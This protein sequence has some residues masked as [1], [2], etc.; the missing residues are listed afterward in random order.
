MKG[1]TIDL[2]QVIA[3]A[4][5][6]VI[7]ERDPNSTKDQCFEQCRHALETLSVLLP[8]SRFL[9]SYQKKYVP[10]NKTHVVFVV[11]GL[12]EAKR[13]SLDSLNSD[14][15][16]FVDSDAIRKSLLDGTLKHENTNMAI[17]NDEK[18]FGSPERRIIP[19]L[20]IVLTIIGWIGQ[21][22]DNAIDSCVLMYPFIADDQIP[23]VSA[24][25]LA[26]FISPNHPLPECI[27]TVPQEVRDAFVRT[28]IAMSPPD[29]QHHIKTEWVAK[30]RKCACCK[31]LQR[32]M[33]ICSGCG[34]Y[35]LCSSTCQH[36]F[37]RNGHKT[38]CANK[39]Q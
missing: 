18:I 16:V 4:R 13:F 35:A 19:S 3:R 8:Q 15:C 20:V 30:L 6:N 22:G 29:V 5:L 37:W 23:P 33:M 36:L 27:H 34:I 17:L 10:E 31:R 32:K 26:K 9:Q 28:A 21:D 11:R 7:N 2:N 38:E 39:K 12:P 24:K 25:H 1:P 14:N